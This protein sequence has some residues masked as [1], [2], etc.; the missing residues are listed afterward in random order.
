MSLCK[1]VV[2]IWREPARHVILFAVICFRR[3][4]LSFWRGPITSA[5]IVRGF[6]LFATS[7]AMGLAHKSPELDDMSFVVGG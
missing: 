3:V 1:E 5:L 6:A 2:D 4:I 7:A